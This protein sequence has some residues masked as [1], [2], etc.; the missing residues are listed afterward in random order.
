MPKMLIFDIWGRYAHF[1][2]I[3]AT[4]S[5]LS[6]IIP[7][8]TALYG[9]VGAILGLEKFDNAY[10]E[11]FTPGAC[12][13]GIQVINPI[14]M[15]RINTN[16]H[17]HDKGL[18]KASQKR[19]PTTMEYVYSPKYRIFLT[20]ADRTLFEELEGHLKSHTAVYTPTLGLA[21]LLSDFQWVGTV[22]V[23]EN[24]LAQPM[25]IEIE[26]VIPREAFVRFDLL[27][28]AGNE[29]IEYS[30]FAVEMNISREVTHRTDVLIDRNGKP[31]LTLV[32][33]YHTFQKDG[34]EHNI[35]IF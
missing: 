12:R 9:Y 16:L 15:Q 30:Q 31:I 32:N 22:E 11:A 8:K 25:S 7:S 35:I 21:N 20:H 3:Y 24:Q 13:L 17:P 6:Y 18:I 26:S 10:L 27:P 29:I 5:A 23:E 1:K 4:T 19:K 14:V 33:Y 2:K 28:E 34:T